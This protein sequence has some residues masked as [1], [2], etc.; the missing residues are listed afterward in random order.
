MFRDTIEPADGKRTG[1]ITSEGRSS[2]LPLGSPVDISV[3]PL[4]GVKVAVKESTSL[5]WRKNRTLTKR[6]AVAVV[7]GT[8]WFWTLQLGKFL[9][10]K[11]ATQLL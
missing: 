10:L 5:G 1:M 9:S 4:P 3:A 8:D 2:L 11:S 6:R 7:K